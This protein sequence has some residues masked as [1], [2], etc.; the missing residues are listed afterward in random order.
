[1]LRAITVCASD[2]ALAS[3][4]AQQFLLTATQ[5]RHIVQALYGAAFSLGLNL[6]R[7]AC[8]NVLTGRNW[9]LLICQCQY[10]CAL[11]LSR[12]RANSFAV[13]KSASL[14]RHLHCASVGGGAQTSSTTPTFLRRNYAYLY[15]SA[16]P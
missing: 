9:K 6:H 13:R 7:P 15:S 12:T 8:F 4:D 1:K 2:G 11:S 14:R 10:N 16:R 3:S 5:G